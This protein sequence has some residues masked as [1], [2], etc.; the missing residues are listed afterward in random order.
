MKSRKSADATDAEKSSKLTSWVRGTVCKK[1]A[2][3]SVRAN[4][5]YHIEVKDYLAQW[6]F[7]RSGSK[8][9]MRLQNTK[10]QEYHTGAETPKSFYPNVEE[11]VLCIKKPQLQC[12]LC[13]WAPH[14]EKNEGKLK[15]VL[16]EAIE[17]IP[18]SKK[19]QTYGSWKLHW[20]L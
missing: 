1:K 20:S 15:T 9:S 2:C 7:C 8:V 12:F 17:V 3:D 16:W 11:G 4:A 6:A 18:A 13:L 14:F 19:S 5:K 10:N